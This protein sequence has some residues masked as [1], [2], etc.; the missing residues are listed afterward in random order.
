MAK[1]EE[2]IPIVKEV[3]GGYVNNPND[4]GGETNMGITIGTWKQAGHD[5]STR[6]AVVKVGN[7]AYT[8]A[9]KSLYEMTDEQWE[10]IAKPMYWDR[11]RADEINNQSIANLVVDWLWG[12]GIY[13][14]KYPQQILGVNADGIVGAKTLAA[15]NDYPNQKELFKKLWERRKQHFINLAKQ[16]GQ[17]IFLKGWLNRMNY[18]KF[19]N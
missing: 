18:F 11:W 9:T 10:A 17:S 1:I 3:E 16:P 8:N 4:K 7:K 15:V 2:W 12:S 13:G 19:N 6:I 5:T 14:I